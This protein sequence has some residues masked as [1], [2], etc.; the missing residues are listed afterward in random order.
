VLRLGLA[1]EETPA[2][3]L[4]GLALCDRLAVTTSLPLF[5]PRQIQL[6]IDDQRITVPEGT[7][8]WEAAKRIGIAI[9]V[10]CH[11]ERLRP[12]GVC[13]MCVVDVGARV[14]VASCVRP[15]EPNMS[16]VTRSEKV[17]RQ[18]AMLTDLLRG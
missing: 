6:T 17:L 10:L 5:T 14:L 9:P 12:V 4:L 8:I 15:V 1:G 13:R 11:D 7:T 16:V 3:A 18:R 2:D